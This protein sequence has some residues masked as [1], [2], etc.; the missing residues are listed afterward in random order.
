MTLQKAG[1]AT[2]AYFY[3]GFK[4]TQK[5]DLRNALASLLTQLSTRSDSY[6]DI[7]CHVHEAHNNGKYKPSNETMI[8][9]LKEMLALPTQSPVY[10]VLDALDECPNT[11]GIPS[12]REEVLYFLKDLVNARLS[13]LRICVTSRP[14][15]D[16]RAA[17]EPLAFRPLSIHDQKGQKKDIEDYIRF[18]VYEKSETAMGRWRDVDKGLVIDTLSEKADGM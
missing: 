17:L 5:Q 10:I 1:L 3:F 18:V 12:A 16:I 15:V 6:C 11:S 8:T 14:E 2:V 9:C 7:L 13:N 4:D